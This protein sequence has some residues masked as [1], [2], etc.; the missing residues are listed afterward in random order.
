MRQLL[1]AAVVLAAACDNRRTAPSTEATGTGSAAGSAGAAGSASAAGSGTGS[2]ADPWN[3]PSAPAEPD[4]PE[5]RRKRAEAALGR[6]AKIKPVVEKL[7]AL[8]FEHDV[9]TSYQPTAD[10][11]AAVRREIAKELPPE[12]SRALSAALAHI[13]FFPKPIDLA[14]VQEQAMITQAGAYYDPA[15][16]SFFLVMAPDSDLVLDTISAHELTHALQDQRFDLARYL[17]SDR[18][19]EDDAAAARRFVV[20][21]DATF[22]M[23]LYGLH[24]V[25]GDKLTPQVIAMLRSQIEKLAALDVDGLKAQARDQSGAFGMMDAD[26]K[27]AVDAMDEIPPAVLVPLLDSYMKGAVVALTAYERGGWPSVDELYRKPPESTE[28]VLHPATKLIPVRERPRRVALAKPQDEELV[29]N[30]LGELQWKI[31]FEQWKSAGAAD[32]AAGWGGDRYSVTRRKDGRLVGRIATTWDTARD[33]EQFAT[34]YVASLAA[35][36]PGADT[37]Q[38]ATGVARPDGTKVLVRTTGKHVFIVD[39]A[40]APAELDALVRAAKI[41]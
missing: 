21:G 2:A 25:I 22:V 36:F 37:S 26:I 30:V 24:G 1:L 5:R 10:F 13:G 33:A 35:R 38:P 7:R 39:G 12:R 14:A 6:V 28:Q 40:D 34:A 3:A 23:L 41:D 4:T 27:K 18:S 8:R 31:Y 17:P 16:K 19:V 9:P 11:Q 29:G 20:E 32:A 15:V